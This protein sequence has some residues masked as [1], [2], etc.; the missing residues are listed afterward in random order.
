MGSQFHTATFDGNLTRAEVKSRYEDL[1]D[2]ERYEYGAGGYS[3]TFATLNGLRIM[4]TVFGSESEASDY[5]EKHAEKRGAAIAAKYKDRREVFKSRPTFNGKTDGTVSLDPERLFASFGEKCAKCVS[6][7]L[8]PGTF[9]LRFVLADQLTQ[10]QKDR[11][12]A[13]LD[14]LAV[15]SRNFKQLSEQ[16]KALL[17]KAGN[18][19]EE[20]S[21][22]DFKNLKG[23]RKELLKVKAKRDKLLA[24]FAALDESLGEKLWQKGSED[25]GTKWLVAGWCAS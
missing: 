3:G 2:D 7:E 13:A 8:I 25:H 15:E 17:A 6:T 1:V 19:S 21:A 12:K 4:D 10:G 9:D 22:E 5:I 16:L 14:P 11:L 18:L 20:F 24:K 23:V